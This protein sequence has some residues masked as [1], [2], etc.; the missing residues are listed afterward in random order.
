[1]KEIF[2]NA[3]DW[4][5]VKLNGAAI[6]LAVVTWSTILAWLAGIATI[7]TIVYNGIRIYKELTKK[8]T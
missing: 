7:S 8:N 2:L 1:M 4:V 6:V 3:I 5:S